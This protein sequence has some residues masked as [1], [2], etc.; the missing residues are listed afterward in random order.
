MLKNLVIATLLV[1]AIAL[2]SAASA[3]DFD[4]QQWVADNNEQGFNN[5]SAFSMTRSGLTLTATATEQPDSV[6]SHVYMD[7]LHNSIIGGMGVC[8]SIDFSMQCINSGDDNVSID[9]LNTE[10]L[11]W[12]FNQNITGVT[13]ELGNA[14]HFDYVSSD[15]FYQYD[16]QGWVQVT[17]TA[18]AMVALNLD[19]SSSMISFKAVGNASAD[20]FYIRNATVNAVPIPAA[21][22][23][24]G[25][26]LFGLAGAARRRA[27]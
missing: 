13:L 5:S 26:A 22:W 3:A 7:D 8:S 9:G 20:H 11:T 12:D 27:A 23:L 24:F 16:S 17:S 4:F 19:G 25:S 21:A 10:I 6:D 2:P 15:I 18:E 1:S 14:N